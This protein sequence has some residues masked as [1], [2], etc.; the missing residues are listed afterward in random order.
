MSDD[1]LVTVGE[2]GGLAEMLAG[3]IRGNVQAD[4]ERKRH[5]RGRGGTVNIRARDVGET[6]GL[7]LGGGHVLVQG[8]PH[9]KPD[10]EIL[11]DADSLMSFSTVPLRLGFPDAMTSDGRALTKSILKRQV[12]V[13][14]LALHPNLVRRLQLLM[15]VT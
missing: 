10:V 8:V 12:I 2:L 15:T 13:R 6:V 9:P 1:W 3:L 14:G 5:M 4:P 11:A 7:T